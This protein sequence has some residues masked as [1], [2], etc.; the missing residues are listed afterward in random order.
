MDAGH[1]GE[2]IGRARGQPI[3][4]HQEARHLLPGDGLLRAEEARSATKGDAGGGDPVDVGLVDRPGVVG[5]ASTPW[6]GR[7]RALTRK[8]AIWP[9]LT[10]SFG[11]NQSLNGGLQPSVTRRPPPTRCRRERVAVVV[12][13]AA[14]EV[15]DRPVG[16]DT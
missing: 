10:A 16:A 3:G 1:V 9:R 5:E 13:K 12:G 4:P 2:R 15:I 14:G 8:L 6:S 7:A 11:Q